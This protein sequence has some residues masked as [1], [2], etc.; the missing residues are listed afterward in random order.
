MKRPLALIVDDDRALLETIADGLTVRGIDTLAFSDPAAALAEIARGRH[1]VLVTDL[2]MPKHDGLSL[3]ERSLQSAADCPVIVMT[4]YSGVDSA[5]ESIRRGAYHYLTKPFKTEELALFIQ[6]AVDDAA[7]RRETR[8]LKRAL[9]RSY[10]LENLIG[11]S[12]AM[13]ELADNVRRVADARV[14]VL[15]LGETGTGKGVIARAL[16]AESGR[17]ERAYIP[18]NCA[19]LPENLLESELFGHAKGAFTGATAARMG[20]FEAADG[21]SLFLDEVAEMAPAL[22]A[23]LLHVLETGKVRPLGETRERAVDVRVIAATHRDLKKRVADGSF[24]EDLLYRLDVIS[25]EVPALRFRRDDIPSLVAHF[26]QALREKHPSAVPRRLSAA[27]LQALS[28]YPWPGNVRELEHA[29]ERV[30]LLGRHEEADPS[31]LPKSVQ[32]RASQPGQID[33]G[34]SVLPMRELQRRYASWALAHCGGE[35]RA[36]CEALEIDYKTLMRH[37]APLVPSE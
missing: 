37:I 18:V 21:G 23:K 12:A 5:I 7:L 1:D 17:A 32:A 3:L 16:H 8:T 33:F 35:K 31:D 28:E 29:L 11:S 27:A 14:P 4:A 2:R 6:R 22:Q 30:V 13:R 9:R 36:T 20:L 19:A 15:I 24:R 26:M 34:A 10:A 25:L